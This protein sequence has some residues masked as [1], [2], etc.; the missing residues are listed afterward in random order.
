MM[1]IGNERIPAALIRVAWSSKGETHRVAM[2]AMSRLAL[3]AN[4]ELD[5]KQ[6]PLEPIQPIGFQTSAE[7]LSSIPFEKAWP[8]YL[9]SVDDDDWFELLDI[10][11]NKTNKVADREQKLRLMIASQR[12]TRSYGLRLTALRF[13]GKS[14][15]RPDALKDLLNV[16][17]PIQVTSLAI[18][19]SKEISAEQSQA[20]W[21]R[22]VAA[23]DPW[24]RLAAHANAALACGKGLPS[25]PDDLSDAQSFSGYL[26]AVEEANANCL[27][28]IWKVSPP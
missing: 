12:F 2:R 22:A 13:L 8:Q 24:L 19:F 28:T 14:L 9:E 3:T 23:A 16:S 11:S 26:K 18:V 4:S 10:L 6:D 27:R 20:A 25:A 17:S 1:R 21:H 5:Y 7:L 15:L